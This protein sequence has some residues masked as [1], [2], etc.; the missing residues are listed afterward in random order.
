LSRGRVEDSV[1]LGCDAVSLGTAHPMT[2]HHIPSGT[3]VRTSDIISRSVKNT[4]SILTDFVTVQDV[5]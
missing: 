2:W 5:P 3:G 4:K 1:L